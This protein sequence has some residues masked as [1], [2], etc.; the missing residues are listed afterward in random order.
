MIER[1]F[2]AGKSSSAMWRDIIATSSTGALTSAEFA[3]ALERSLRR[4]NG[5]PVVS[6]G[7]PGRK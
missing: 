5:R 7:N 1:L 6:A 3:E 2:H 4:K